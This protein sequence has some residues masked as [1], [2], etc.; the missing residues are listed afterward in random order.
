MTIKMT[1]EDFLKK[2]INI[3]LEEYG[4]RLKEKKRLER[5]LYAV[6]IA[7]YD[8]QDSIEV[9]ESSNDTEDARYK[10]HL[11]NLKRLLEKKETY[12]QK[13]KELGI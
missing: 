9:F 10:R 6:N 2:P 7:I 1:M 3:T 4:K 8:T 5:I 12:S 13:I 11:D